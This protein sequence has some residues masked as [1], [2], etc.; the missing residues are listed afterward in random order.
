MST[1]VSV[2]PVGMALPA[3]LMTADAAE[4]I[5]AAN[6]AAAGGIKAGGFPRISIKGGKFHEVE[7]GETRTYFHPQQPG[8]PLLPMM[9]LEVAILNAN[10]NLTKT[11]YEGEYKEGDDKEPTC[12]SD[13]GKTPDSHITAPQHANCAE[14]P[15]NQWGSRISK[16]S[17]KDTKACSDNKRL[18]VLP[19]GDLSY[20]AL[21]L[22]ITPS[23][24]SDWGKYVKALTERNIPV[25]AVATNLT[26]DASAAHPKVQFSYS[27]FLTEAEYAKVKERMVGDDVKTII[28][29]TRTIAIKPAATTTTQAPVLAATTG[30][31]QATPTVAAS[32]TPPV[33]V[34]VDPYA[35]QP[36]HVK[37][38]VEGAGGLT[39]VPG[40]SVYKS[41]TGVDYVAAPP[42]PVVVDPFAGQPP[43]V[44][45]AVDGAGGLGTPAGD[46]TY[47]ALTQKD[48]PAVV[49]QV[50]VAATNA[51]APAAS[52]FG[53][54]VAPAAPA[55]AAPVADKPKR[56]PR[57]KPPEA[58]AA[59]A[60]D[61][62]LAHLSE[63]IRNAVIAVG[64]DTAAGIALLAQFPAPAGTAAPA[65]PAPVAPA[66]PTVGFGGVPVT[67][68]AVG[69][70]AE[71]SAAA[72][73]LAAK[74]KAKLA[75]SA[76]APAGATIQ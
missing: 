1:A 44:K 55:A 66:A 24:L 63:G 42:A 61:P 57:V 8:Q 41:L 9:C 64:K 3:H 10:Q 17:G 14:C 51:P 58:P 43:H 52:G 50:A 22:S 23:S 29:P 4:Q 13:N 37:M 47:K 38:A 75:Q 21:G 65:A 45:A 76:A 11:F 74:L 46:A 19:A 67:I 16:V 56:T 5:A 40:L 49:D 71:V 26:F 72:S 48:A 27:R 70:S 2:I 12:S 18:A 28:A 39:S 15:M 25:N 30:V 7:G 6:A 32:A 53:A 62:A 36:A 20:K 60:V 59:T 31:N 33:P 35:G 34:V 73:S 68:P 69:P 54:A